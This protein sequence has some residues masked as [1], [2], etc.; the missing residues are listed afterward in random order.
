MLAFEPFRSYLDANL[1]AGVT[2][3]R[4]VRNIALLTE[5]ISKYEYL[6]R[7]DILK[8]KYIDRD[9]EKLFNLYLRLLAKDGMGEYEDDS[10]YAPSGCVSFLT[11]HQSKGMEFPIVFVDSLNASPRRQNEGMLATVSKYLHRKPFEPEESIKYFDFWRLYYTAFSR[12]QDLLV[13]TCNEKNGKGKTPSAYF[14]KPYASLKSVNSSD[15]DIN[16]F[17]FSDVKDVNLKESFSFTSHIGVYERC[18]LQYKFFKEL[19]FATVRMGATIFGSLVHQTIEDVHRAALRGAPQL[20]TPENIAQWLDANYATLSK[21]EHA[22]LGEKQIL[23]A[24]EHVKR[25]VYEPSGEKNWSRIQDAEV[26]ITLVKEGYIIEGNIDLIQG[27]GDTVEL[28]DFKSE[29]KPNIETEKDRIEFYRRQLE[30]YAHLVE[31]KTNKTVSGM[32]LYYTG[33][34]SNEREIA[35]LRDKA[36]IAKTV[37]NFDQIVKKI[38]RK[39][40]SSKSNISHVCENC[41]FRYYCKKEV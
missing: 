31:E 20:I 19:G 16:D 26:E 13:L 6:H 1:G 28:V 41:D 24:L 23:A 4:P 15:F 27:E 3:L 30:L 10:E 5:I 17:S 36:S 2:D 39:D 29:K 34:E 25:Y 8:A 35:F 14:E 40:F 22:Y 18:S 12:A 38:Q 7:I 37:E 33:E 32:K 11:I 21:K 9:V